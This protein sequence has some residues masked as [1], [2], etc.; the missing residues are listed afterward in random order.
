MAPSKKVLLTGV[1]G[2]LGSHTTI[3]LLNRGYTVTGTL[4]RMDRG[5]SLREILARHTPHID[6]LRF[7]EAELEDQEVW[8]KLMD[9]VDYVQHIASPFPRVLPE[10]EEDLIIPARA[11]VL[12]VLKAAAAKQVKRVVMTSSSGAIVYGKDRADRSGTFDESDWTDVSKRE[13]TTPYFRS[14]TIAEKAA[15]DFIANEGKG[16]ELAVICPGAI[17]GPVLEQDFGTSANIVIKTMDGSSPA[18]PRIG[19]DIVDVRSVADLQI[20]AM[21][22]PEAANQRFIGSAGFLSFKAVADILREAYPDRRIPRMILPNFAVRLFARIDKTLQPILLDLGTERKVDNRKARNL[23]NWKPIPV[24][25]AVLSCAES[26][27]ELNL[28]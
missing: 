2:F 8:M 21:E 19:F 17:L 27:I 6:R 4:R 13:D 11:G 22:A 24:K 9:G 28:V 20:R 5:D 3:Q 12:N 15:W 16:L 23:L 7:A 10:R 1:S 14:K 18:I 26:V 25:E